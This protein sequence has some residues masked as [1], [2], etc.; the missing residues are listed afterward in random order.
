MGRVTGT[1]LLFARLKTSEDSPGIGKGARTFA[2]P[3]QKRATDTLQFSHLQNLLNLFPCPAWIEDASGCV[4]VRN[5]HKVAGASCSRSGGQDALTT[6]KTAAF[7]LILP[8]EYTGWGATLPC[9]LTGKLPVPRDSQAPRLIAQ[10]PAGL[11]TEYQRCIISALLAF[12]IKT[13]Q[14]R[15]TPAVDEA[16]LASLT[17]QQRKIYPEITPGCSLKEI[18]AQLKLSH[19]TVR[20]QVSRMRKILGVDL[21]PYQRKK[22]R[23]LAN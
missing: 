6:L 15:Q 22:R 23:R 14:P 10:F 12:L 20:F 13:L 4:L 8:G 9:E 19:G 1:S 5:E 17:P 2:M 3:N 21:L 16:L 11:E 18:A 7:P